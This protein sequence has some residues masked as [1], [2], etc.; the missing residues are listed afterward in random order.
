KLSPLIDFDNALIPGQMPNENA[1]RSAPFKDLVGWLQ[2]ELDIRGAELLDPVAP[3][4]QAAPAIIPP[5]PE[6]SKG[7][8]EPQPGFYQ[9]FPEVTADKRWYFYWDMNA[10]SLKDMGALPTADVS[11]KL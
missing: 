10:W 11:G 4:T 1:F 3:G 5:G 6:D 7:K 9:G 8:F 2:G